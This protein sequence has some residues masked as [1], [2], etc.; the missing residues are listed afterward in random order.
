MKYKLKI[1]KYVFEIK[2][3]ESVD[4]EAE[5]KKLEKHHQEETQELI[6]KIGELEQE[7]ADLYETLVPV[8]EFDLF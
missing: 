6:K 8:D 5:Y 7:L 3:G 1:K 4:W 2:D